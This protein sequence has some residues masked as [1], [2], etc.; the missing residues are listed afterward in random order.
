MSTVMYSIEVILKNYTYAP[1]K[2]YDRPV[3]VCVNIKILYIR[4]LYTE[5]CSIVH[6]R[7]WFSFL[8]TNCSFLDSTA[9]CTK[10]ILTPCSLVPFFF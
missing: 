5:K 6:W 10:G 7:Y 4:K 8:Q 2:P 9:M 3:C 1:L